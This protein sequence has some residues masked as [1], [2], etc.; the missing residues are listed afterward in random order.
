LMS[1]KAIVRFPSSII[2][3]GICPAAIPQNKQSGTLRS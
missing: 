3:A 1:R 2:V